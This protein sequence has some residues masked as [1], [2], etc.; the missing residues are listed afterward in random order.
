MRLKLAP[1]LLIALSA[2]SFDHAKEEVN[3]VVVIDSLSSQFD[4][5]DSI[6]FSK[7]VFPIFETHCNFPQ[8]HKSPNGQATVYFESYIDIAYS[9]GAILGTLTQ[10]DRTKMP[11]DT[12]TLQPG[13]K[14]ADSLINIIECW[15]EQRKPN[16]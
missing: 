8:C 3:P 7:D 1:F 5:C 9:T 10:K 13:P 16:N 4:P 14:L 11:L 6:S 15:K 12:I 2:C